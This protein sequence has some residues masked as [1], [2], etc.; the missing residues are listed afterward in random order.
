MK[1]TIIPPRYTRTQRSPKKDSLFDKK[2]P[3]RLNL[4]III[5]DSKKKGVLFLLKNV[6][7][8]IINKTL[9]KIIIFYIFLNYFFYIFYTENES[10]I[11]VLKSFSLPPP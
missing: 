5:I 9:N 10:N 2:K 8:E 6:K 4:I 3:E 11:F 7:K 1:I